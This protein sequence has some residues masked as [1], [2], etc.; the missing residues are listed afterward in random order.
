M[1]GLRAGAIRRTLL[2]IEMNSFLII[3]GIVPEHPPEFQSKA[4]NFVMRVISGFQG[5]VITTGSGKAS[6]AFG[7]LTLNLGARIP[8]PGL[9]W[10]T[11]GIQAIAR[12]MV[13]RYS[14]A[15]KQSPEPGSQHYRP[16]GLPRRR[17]LL[18]PRRGSVRGGWYG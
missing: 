2:F 1:Q 13:I 3:I 9:G 14:S 7:N 17:A 5:E 4:A 15:P 18:D 11:Q 16:K 6:T 10:Q 12:V 8:M